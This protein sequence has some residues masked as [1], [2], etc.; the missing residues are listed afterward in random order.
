LFVNVCLTAANHQ[1]TAE[2]ETFEEFAYLQAT[3]RIQYAQGYYFAKP[4]MLEDFERTQ[5]ASTATIGR[6]RADNRGARSTRTS[7]AAARG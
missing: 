5:L 2:P 7:E 1:P 6:E 3:T 4:F